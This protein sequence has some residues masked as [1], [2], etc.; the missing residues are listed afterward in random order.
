M[1]GEA[2]GNANGLMSRGSMK[3][4]TGFLWPNS[5]SLALMVMVLTLIWIAVT[6][7]RGENVQYDDPN[8]AIKKYHEAVEQDMPDPDSIGFIPSCQ[9]VVMYHDQKG[10]GLGAQVL[11]VLDSYLLARQLNATLLVARQMYWNYGCDMYLTW[12]CYFEPVTPYC[13]GSDGELRRVSRAQM[14][15]PLVFT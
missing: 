3:M 9:R 5:R 7:H 4:R 11:R 8:T 6:V 1:S 12:E 15:P 13:E 14:P 10:N 2:V